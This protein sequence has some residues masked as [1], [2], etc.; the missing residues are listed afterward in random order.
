MKS[1]FVFTV[2][3]MGKTILILFND[4]ILNINKSNYVPL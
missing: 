4:N 1:Y 3:D 2:W